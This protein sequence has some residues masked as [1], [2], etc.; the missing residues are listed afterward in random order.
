MNISQKHYMSPN[1]ALW[2]GRVDGTTDS[3]LR[4]HQQVVIRDLSVGLEQANESVVSVALLGFACDVGVQRNQG[5]AGAAEGPAAIRTM[6]HSLPVHF[7]SNTSLYDCGDIVCPDSDLESAQSALSDAIAYLIR[8][9]CFPIVLGGGHEVMYGHFSGLRKVLQG[10]IGVI[11]IDAHFDLR[12][13]I[14]SQASSG[15]GFYQIHQDLEERGESYHY[16]ALGIQQISNTRRL[17]D[18]ADAWHVDYST[19]D[20]FC[21]EGVGEICT[22]IRSFAEQVDHVYLT[23]DLDAF[24]IPY[25]PGVSAPA[26]HGIIPDSNF[27]TCLRHI[28]MLQNLVSVDFAELNPRF[29]IDQRTARLAAD[30]IFRVVNSR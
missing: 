6:L 27:I 2:T 17:F 3:D 24:A 21:L 10:K 5:R 15:T 11:N 9:Q 30:L 26:F 28:L 7:G 12:E 22:R 18:R 23:I 25:A 13:P 14:A 4:W 29:D 1:P 19:A 20:A 8:H 16:M